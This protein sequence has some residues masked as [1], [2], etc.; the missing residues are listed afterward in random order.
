MLDQLRAP[1]VLLVAALV[2]LVIGGT[3]LGSALHSQ[4]EA[5]REL[6]GLRVALSNLE[7]VTQARIDQ[8]HGQRSLALTPADDDAYTVHVDRLRELAPDTSEAGLEQLIATDSL[9]GT[10]DEPTALMLD[11]SS[12]LD[13][14]ARDT[15]QPAQ[16][17]LDGAQTQ[18]QWALWLTGLSVSALL[19]LVLIRGGREYA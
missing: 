2:L 6:A 8:A 17:R 9:I 1:R 12:T 19:V 7:M 5:Q 13:D 14:L 10:A 18:S 11:L 16:D 4:R 3:V 15:T